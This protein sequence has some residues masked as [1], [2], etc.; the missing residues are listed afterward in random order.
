MR[1]GAIPEL[2]NAIAKSLEEH[3]IKTDAIF[4]S[5]AP[6]DILRKLPLGSISLG[7]IN[8]CKEIVARVSAAP[9]QSASSLLKSVPQKPSSMNVELPLSLEPVQS[10][11]SPHTDKVVELSGDRNS[12]KSEFFL[13]I[14]L[15]YLTTN[16][17]SI[18]HWVD[19]TGDFST[20]KASNILKQFGLDK[21]NNCLERIHVSLALE[22]EQ[23]Y[24]ILDGLATSLEV[25]CPNGISATGY[26][27]VDNVTALYGPLLSVAS[28]QG[29][30]LMVDLMRRLR[31]I[32]QTHLIT[33]IVCLS[34]NYIYETV[35]TSLVHRKPALGPSFTFLTDATLWMSD[36]RLV[37]KSPGATYHNEKSDYINYLLEVT[38]SS[39]G[40]R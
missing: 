14:V 17:R 4:L 40:V 5:M 29:H 6:L 13:N 16:A 35:T 3:G 26:L 38:K 2:P 37:T 7:E 31:I 36:P 12:R 20:T 33:V 34:A 19:T 15:R 23:L 25:R 18:V 30:A 24:D 39:F 27:V 22:V 11:F 10:Y 1:L 9:G 32:S 8:R 21:E 28:S